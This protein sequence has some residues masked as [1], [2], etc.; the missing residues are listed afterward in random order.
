VN[1]HDIGAI[2]AETGKAVVQT[3]SG[4]FG[5][6]YRVWWETQFSEE[7]WARLREI[8][9]RE[10]MKEALPRM[11]QSWELAAQGEPIPITPEAIE[12]HQI[13]TRLLAMIE[14]AVANATA[15]GKESSG[16]SPGS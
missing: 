16:T 9:T 10:Y 5:I 14:R 6:V 7:D 3:A 4:S 1:L 15:L 8:S 2:L 13:P 11:L 12:Q